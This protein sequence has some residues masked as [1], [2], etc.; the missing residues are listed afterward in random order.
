MRVRHVG[1][2]GVVRFLGRVADLWLFV[3]GCS[4]FDADDLGGADGGSCV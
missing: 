4:R 1:G 3:C 2:V